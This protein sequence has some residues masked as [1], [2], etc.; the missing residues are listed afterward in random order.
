MLLHAAESITHACTRLVCNPKCFPPFSALRF[1]AGASAASSLPSYTFQNGSL[2]LSTKAFITS[3]LLPSGID[4]YDCLVNHGTLTADY[5]RPPR[6]FFRMDV[7]EASIGEFENAW[8]GLEAEFDPI[9]HRWLNSSH[10]MAVGILRYLGG[11]IASDV[12]PSSTG[13]IAFSTDGGLTFA[14]HEGVPTTLQT[15]GTT[16]DKG[17]WITDQMIVVCGGVACAASGDG[18][19]TFNEFVPMISIGLHFDSNGGLN[20]YVTS[21]AYH[22]YRTPASDGQ[23]RML[24]MYNEPLLKSVMVE[25][26]LNITKSSVNVT[27]HWGKRVSCHNQTYILTPKSVA[28]SPLGTLS[29]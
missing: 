5:L 15:D 3:N 13:G 10:V 2:D 29:E 28:V 16:F 9:V 8:T 12:Y 7:D 24:V 27:K 11:T 22:I 20:S 1:V 4:P 17:E 19:K 14:D 21:P 6:Q 23:A 18:G 26:R 25:F